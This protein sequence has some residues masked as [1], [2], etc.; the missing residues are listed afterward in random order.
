ML[1]A[2]DLPNVILINE[3]IPKAQSAPIGRAF[4]NYTNFDPE[5]CDLGSSWYNYLCV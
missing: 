2:N 4:L 3:T 1:I 5:L